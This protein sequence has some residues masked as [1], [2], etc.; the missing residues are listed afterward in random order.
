MMGRITGNIIFVSPIEAIRES[1]RLYRKM[2][3]AIETNLL[4][5]KK[6]TSS[7]YQH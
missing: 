7:L 4:L 2:C 1:R 5:H 3:I 6:F